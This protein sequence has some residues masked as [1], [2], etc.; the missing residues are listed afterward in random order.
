[1]GTGFWIFEGICGVIVLIWIIETIYCKIKGVPT[2]REKQ[3]IAKQNMELAKYRNK[4]DDELEKLYKEQCDF[5]KSYG[6]SYGVDGGAAFKGAVNVLNKVQLVQL[7]KELSLMEA[8]LR[9][10]GL[11]TDY[12][13]YKNVKAAKVKSNPNSTK[14]ASVVG[15]AVAGGIVAGPVGAVVGAVSAADKNAKNRANK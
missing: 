7:K 2:T 10:R 1:M 6:V 13:S 5:A 9:E 15:R 11:P 8:V 4:S 3:K 14:D 12:E